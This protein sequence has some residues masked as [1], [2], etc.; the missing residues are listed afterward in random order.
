V[1]LRA[2]NP[3]LQYTLPEAGFMLWSD[4]W[5][6]PKNAAHKTNAEKLINFYFDP[7]NAA[8]LEDYV[9]YISPVVGAKDKL[10]ANDPDVANNPLI[11]PDDA[12]RARSKAFMALTEEQ[13]TKYN[14]AFQKVMGA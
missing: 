7:E 5:C 12:T 3:D 2:D 1:Q 4:N 11:F 8:E 13:E 9:N 6:I 10:L 14:E